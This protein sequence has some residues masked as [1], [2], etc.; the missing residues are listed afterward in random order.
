MFKKIIFY[1]SPHWVEYKINTLSA[2]KFCRRNKITI[3][4]N[5]NN[6][7]DLFFIRKRGDI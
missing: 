3:A 1:C 2:G 5:Q 7:V 4:S 6:L